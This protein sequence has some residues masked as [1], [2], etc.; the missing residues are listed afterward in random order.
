M[1]THNPFIAAPRDYERGQVSWSAV[2]A[3]LISKAA[4]RLAPYLS[5]TP[6][7]PSRS[8]PGVRLKAESL[9]P[10]GSFKVRTALSQLSAVADEA[11][12][13][14]VVTSSS[15]N[16]AQGAAWAAGLLGI[17]VKVVMMQ[18][19][20]P[21][22]VER[23]RRLGGE[24]VFCEDAFPA[25]ARKVAEI[26]RDEGR[27]VIFPFDHPLAVAGNAGV[28]LEILD[29]APD[30]RRIV[31]PVSG[32]GLISGIIQAVRL[33]KRPVEVWGVQP[34]GSDAT[35]QSFHRGVPVRLEGTRTVCDGLTVT[36]P[37]KVTFPLILSGAAGMLRIPEDAVLAATRTCLLEEKLVVEPSGAITLAAI[38]CG[39][40]PA[41]GTVCV[42]SGG[43]LDP[44][45]LPRLNL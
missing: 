7:L 30:V 33:S 32:G 5:P 14:G 29:Q 40:L 17:S 37:G 3:D 16:F 35:Y 41:E 13:Q 31:V 18:S 11:R 19:S 27:I 26:E 42:L 36:D 2:N 20:N 1:P 44:R 8:R 23:T 43:N 38:L 34:E 28:G 39:L 25:R 10:T 6:C 12:S 4:S 45:L 9:Q 21:L 15:G 24:V 22:K